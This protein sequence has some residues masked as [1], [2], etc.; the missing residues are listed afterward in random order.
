MI[1]GLLK[2]AILHV[3]YDRIVSTQERA[4]TPDVFDFRSGFKRQ[5]LSE[6]GAAST[7]ERSSREQFFIDFNLHTGDDPSE[8]ASALEE[9]G[10]TLGE[11]LDLL[12]R[13]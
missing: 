6:Q 1:A 11:W 10:L 9:T 7:S 13:G 3:R 12:S 8:L 5:L 2:Y 4:R